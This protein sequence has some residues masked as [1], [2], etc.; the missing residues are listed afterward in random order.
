MRAIA[1]AGEH[2]LTQ[3]E[4]AAAALDPGSA[5]VDQRSLAQFMVFA[6]EYA[7]LLNFHDLD[8]NVTGDWQ[9]FFDVDMSFLLAEVSMLNLKNESFDEVRLMRRMESTLDASKQLLEHIYTLAQRID[10]W[11]QRTMFAGHAELARPSAKHASAPV[12]TLAI[13]S[14]I[15]EKLV[16]CLAPILADRHY[17]AIW[18]KIYSRE[19]GEQDGMAWYHCAPW[20]AELAA[21]GGGGQAANTASGGAHAKADPAAAT[22]SEQM[23]IGMLNAI[24]TVNV[25]LC[26]TAAECL[27]RNLDS[28]S[29][30][31]AHTTLVIAF[32]YLLKVLQD[33]VNRFTA[34][35]L[36]HYYRTILALRER[37]GQADSGY[38]M[39]QLAPPFRSLLLPQGSALS[40][41]KDASGVD[42]QY[43]TVQDIVLNQGSVVSLCSLYKVRGDGGPWIERVLAAP[44]ANS[45]DGLGMVAADPACGW[46]V[47][48][49]LD[50]AEVPRSDPRNARLGFAISSPVLALAEGTRHV[51]LSFTFG[52][53]SLDALQQD[54][55][56][57]ARAVY[58]DRAVLF[59]ALFRQ[60][61]SL[62][63]SGAK[64]WIEIERFF[65]RWRQADGA[66]NR[67]DMLFTLAPDQPAVVANGALDGTVDSDFPTIRLL[68]NPAAPVCLVSSFA[69]A[70]LEKIDILV[71]VRGLSKLQLAGS[72]GSMNSA[73]PFFPFGALGECGA[74][75]EFFHPELGK[76]NLS[77]V[78]IAL[79][80]LNLPYTPAS[81]K[82]YFNGYGEGFDTS[83]YLLDLEVYSGRRW[84]RVN[85]STSFPMFADDGPSALLSTRLAFTPPQYGRGTSGVP[86]L[87][88]GD[89]AAGTVRL[90]FAAPDQGFGQAR[91]PQAFAENAF[92]VAR[93]FYAQPGAKPDASAAP[94][95]AAA[96]IKMPL[97][98]KAKALRCNYVA[99]DSLALVG[100]AGDGTARLYDIGPFGSSARQH[101]TRAPLLAD[102][103]Y[104]GRLY[105]GVANMSAPQSISLHFQFLERAASAFELKQ[106]EDVAKAAAIVW[107]Y[108]T[109]DGWRDF[110]KPAVQSNTAEFT[111]S[112]IVKFDL[113]RDISAANT[114]MPTGLYWI[115]ARA[116]R[117]A[118]V[119]AGLR[120]G[121]AAL[122]LLDTLAIA[123]MAQAVAIKRCAPPAASDAPVSL[124]AATIKALVKKTPAI[125]AVVQPYPTSGGA[126]AESA[127]QFRVRVSER[128]KHK[129]RACQ[130]ADYEHI[131]LDRFASLRQVKC[132]G[133]NNSRAFPFEGRVVPGDV[134]VALV[135]AA[136][137]AGLAPP[138]PLPQL[139]AVARYLR[140]YCADV[141]QSI[142]VRNLDYEHVKVFVNVEFSA[143]AD[144]DASIIA[145]NA[146]ISSYLAPW[147]LDRTLA[148]PVGGASV[149]G[150]K[151]ADF[152][153]KEM[154]A[155]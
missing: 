43:A 6:K 66:N 87:A 110:S 39:L 136:A 50:P 67:I 90:T 33:D 86:D 115:E 9:P 3:A 144:I 10:G 52:Q 12:F 145:L 13:E 88:G 75:F 125:A 123:I 106:G 22:P 42:V 147:L 5:E 114:T 99:G 51:K 118:A 131:V 21:A 89:I 41:G 27:Q 91:Y 113:P 137:T 15:R 65:F 7:R 20:T 16:P 108:L 124:P 30:H 100:A 120:A 134:V 17:M 31:P 34:R 101:D 112:G 153:R 19:R 122:N 1:R 58:P 57:Q 24:T 102:D 107:R 4:R 150:Y 25:S 138:L 149:R 94:P 96:L 71:D 36:D 135:P 48:G 103:G 32:G 38:V 80:W 40:A 26:E 69:Q 141:V 98:P 37:G 93:Q 68:L 154:A 111:R 146:A 119:E 109:D 63:V 130:P 82:A 60:G 70:V 126:G 62:A 129:Q 84:L 49:R 55:G 79:D 29:D 46:P 64:R 104:D 81:F 148:L 53:D 142:W 83:D 151:L 139:S 78:C 73:K 61:L 97:V 77:H 140:T 155:L 23:L 11:Y 133:F 35:H 56:A 18:E 74:Y 143:H 47:F 132:I 128:L 117:P 44:V 152:I 127:A 92:L 45:A 85:A 8:A 76:A 116:R 72:V 28:V 95:A 2:G 105:I 54:L 59:P 14:L 121:A